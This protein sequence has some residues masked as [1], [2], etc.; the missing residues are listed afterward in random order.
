MDDGS[1]DASFPR[2]SSI[3]A[4]DATVTVLRFRRNFGQTA[5]LAAGIDRSRGEI[6]V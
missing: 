1:G 6:I 2:L 3:A 4:H 5:A